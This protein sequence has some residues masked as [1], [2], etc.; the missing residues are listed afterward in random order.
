M[1]WAYAD[2]PNLVQSSSS[3]C[4]IVDPAINDVPRSER[5][6][7]RA[8][9]LLSDAQFDNAVRALGH[10]RFPMTR[11]EV[12]KLIELPK[13]QR[14][15]PTQ[16]GVGQRGASAIYRL[17]GP[18]KN[19]LLELWEEQGSAGLSNAVSSARIFYREGVRTYTLYDSRVGPD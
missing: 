9:D 14:E 7:V 16:L 8:S 18:P 17:T 13:V 12:L 2:V 6:P 15:N 10:A 1:R 19:H 4:T 11:A 5:P 3:G